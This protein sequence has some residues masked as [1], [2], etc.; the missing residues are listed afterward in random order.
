M[1]SYFR[2]ILVVTIFSLVSFLGAFVKFG[3]A[4]S[5]ALDSWA[6]FFVAAFF[7]PMYGGAVAAIGHLLSALTGGFPFTPPVH[8][9]VALLQFS[10]ACIFGL[11]TRRSNSIPGIVGASVLAVGLNGVAAPLIIG[12]VFTQLKPAMISLI[13]VLALASAVNVLLATAV[14]LVIRRTRKES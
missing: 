11:I 1:V 2:V 7:G 4:G 6:S 13:P 14:L 9:L 12:T 5:I 8:A 3:G 10:W